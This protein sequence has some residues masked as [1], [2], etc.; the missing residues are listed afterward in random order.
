MRSPVVVHRA[1]W[2]LP[3]AQAPIANSA[4]AIQA[5]RVTAVGGFSEVSRSNADA[6]VVDH[7]DS[8][9]MP[10][11]INAHTHLELSHLA[12]LS[13]QP[14]PATFTGWIEKM[15]AERAKAGFSDEDVK[16][17]AR[18]SLAD[19]QREG[20]IAIGD[21]SNTGLTRELVSDF[22][23]DLLC[24]K[25]YL[26]LRSSGVKPTLQALRAED[27]NLLCTAHAPYSTH[28][29][30]LLALKKRAAKAGHI[31]PIHVA[32]SLAE[33][34]MMSR[35]SGEMRDFLERRGFWDDTFQPTAIDNSGS[36]RYLH[37]M[38]ALDDKTMCVHS[39]HLTD[40]EIELLTQAG[41][42]ICLCPGSN[43]YLDVG[44]APL[45]KYLQKGMLPALGTDS[46]TSNPEISIWREMRLLAEDHPDVDPTDILRMATLGGAEAL[47]LAGDI[48]SLEQGKKDAILAVKLP[49]SFA[50]ALSVIE[51]LVGCGRC[52]SVQLI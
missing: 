41:S 2:I 16:E 34:E 49:E 47:G 33:T 15:L 36:V 19:Q 43:R 46:L 31:F 44:K 17:A 27:D 9:L 29:K 20:V 40:P 21:I 30:L 1:P 6:L 42:K 5:G 10:G 28:A 48:G 14:P 8:A 32:E 4:V 35:G 13:Q 52:E 3:I 50:N 45:E 39:I 23:G 51:Y 38:G 12:Y 24:F 25:E 26:G 11:L 18:K 7:P 37:Q 22:T